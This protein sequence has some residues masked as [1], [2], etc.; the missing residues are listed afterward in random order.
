[1]TENQT[2]TDNSV[3]NNI[4]TAEERAK[5]TPD[6]ILN[7]LK[8]G[9]K[10]FTENNLTIRN[11][12]ERIRKHALGQQPMAVVVSCLDKRIP[13][14]EV[15]HRGL[16]EIFVARVAGNFVNEDILG[17][18]EFACK[19]SSA[20]LIVILGHERCEAVKSAIN[21]V[22]MGNITA[23]LSKI[24]PAVVSA[25][26][27]FAGDKTPSNP[28]YV[29]AVCLQNIHHAIDVIRAQSPI[30]KEMESKNEIKI[31][32]GIYQMETGKV[33]FLEREK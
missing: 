10:E 9:N 26:A 30:L 28:E 25:E 24:R 22:E 27:T 13:H 16:G 14:E 31:V 11:N 8:Q 3:V 2:I 6:D 19:I 5:M 33:K 4:L 15:F 29:N 7:I 32:G 12:S 20:K 17:S 1:M 23:M 21:G 18:L